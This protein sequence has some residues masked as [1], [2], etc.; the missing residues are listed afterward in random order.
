MTQHILHSYSGTYPFPLV[1]KPRSD[2]A[3][4]RSLRLR[5]WLARGLFFVVFAGALTLLG[6]EI[7]AAR[8]VGWDETMK[9][10][11]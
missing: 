11:L 10:L 2:L 8:Q 7:R 9:T 5:I 6:Y 3:E 1:K 4:R